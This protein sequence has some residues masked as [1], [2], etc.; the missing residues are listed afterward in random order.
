VAQWDRASRD[1][2]RALGQLNSAI[3]LASRAQSGIDAYEGA[4][5]AAQRRELDW[6]WEDALA[7]VAGL[8]KAIAEDMPELYRAAG[9]SSRWAP[10]K[11]VSPPRR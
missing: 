3:S 6:A 9:A 5:T 11:P 7:G 8:N 1:A 10:L 2:A 4:P